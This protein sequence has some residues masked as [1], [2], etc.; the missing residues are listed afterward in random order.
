MDDEVHVLRAFDP[1]LSV[2]V[3][4]ELVAGAFEPDLD[5]I[6]LTGLHGLKD[7]TRLCG[8][9]L[10]QPL[11][12]VRAEAL[13]E[14]ALRKEVRAAGGEGACGDN[15]GGGVALHEGTRTLDVAA[16]GVED[17]AAHGGLDRV[18]VLV[19]RHAERDASGARAVELDGLLDLLRIEPAD[20]GRLFKRPGFAAFEQEAPAGLVLDALPGEGAVEGGIERVVPRIGD[21][22]GRI[23][24][25]V[26]DHVGLGV[27]HAEVGGA[28]EQLRLHVDEIR[29]VG[30][31]HHEFMIVQI[32]LHDVLGPAEHKRHVGAWTD[33]KPDVGLGGVG[34]EARVDRDRLD[35]LGTQVRERTAA[36][37]GAAVGDVR[38]PHD[39]ALHLGVGIVDLT[40]LFVG[41][42]RRR[43]AVHHVVGE[44]A[45]QEALGAARLVEVRRAEGI[46]N[47]RN[48]AEC[49]VAATAR[50]EEDGFGAVFATDLLHLAGDRV[51]RLLPGNALPL[52]LA[53]LADAHERI[54]VAVRVI[55]RADAGQAL[56]AHGAVAHRI[57]GVALEL[58]H[59]AVAH[60]RKNGAVVNARATAGLDDLRLA[61]DR[62]CGGRGLRLHQA[63]C[64]GGFNGGGK[65][66]GGRS[67]QECSA[68]E[69]GEVHT[70]LLLGSRSGCRPSTGIGGLCRQSGRGRIALR[71]LK[72]S[73]S[74]IPANRLKLT[75]T[76][77][78]FPNS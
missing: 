58:H 70:L 9:P 8:V 23:R 29:Q 71:S 2:S 12:L 30:P 6:R 35:A 16:Q 46:R 38:A 67:L 28:H 66:G 43:A 10:H 1:V 52:V 41:D 36:A 63:F 51:D 72:V 44:G 55:E 39:E 65:P 7:G 62:A 42:R 48:A 60:V 47:A 20:L 76:L 18:L 11:V 15:V 40:R 74:A 69:F 34:H 54:L 73:P 3:D 50:R 78:F 33:R 26:P 24:L 22:L 25:L 68:V 4:D 45:R 31:A 19:G 37:R 17:D 77:H 13:L 61:F 59:A 14:L 75:E 5:R 56:G 21:G 57:V 64:G 53:A 32:L 27:A 49:G